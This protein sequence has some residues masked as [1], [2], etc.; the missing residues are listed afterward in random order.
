M[1][2]TMEIKALT[3]E[4]LQ[5]ELKKRNNAKSEDRKAYK[6]LV[7]Q[8]LPNS[9]MLLEHA[10]KKLS[11][12]KT[13]V[14]K[15]LLVLLDLKIKAYGIKSGQ[16]SHTF[17]LDNGDT[18]TAGYRILDAW[19]DT[20]NEGIAK[21]NEYLGSLAKDEDSAKL[22][23]TVN[24]LLKK[25]AKGNLKANRVVELRNMADEFDSLLF[26][27]GVEIISK[28]FKPVKSVYFVEAT[29]VTPSGEK[30][31]VPLSISSVPFSSNITINF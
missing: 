27:D 24:M 10:S 26:T 11:E 14:F 3:T 15:N 28:A 9:V 12:T 31:H 2:E 25:D 13:E 20:V 22:V 16:Q 21:V 4:Q 5:A 6:K 18:I 23:K 30:Q 29:V 19:D 17:S 8:H 1:N 7:Q